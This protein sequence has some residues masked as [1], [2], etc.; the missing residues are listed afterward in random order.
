MLCILTGYRVLGI[1]YLDQL[2]GAHHTHTYFIKRRNLEA[3]LNQSCFTLISGS[4][5]SGYYDR[6]PLRGF[7]SFSGGV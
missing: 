3:G 6:P 7:L 4:D 1:V 2:T 5:N